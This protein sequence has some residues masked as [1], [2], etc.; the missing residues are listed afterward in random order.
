[1]SKILITGGT[2]YIGSHTAVE[3]LNNGYEVILL[4]NLSNSK[5]DTLDK[6]Q[7]ITNKNF[8]FYNCDV[9]H[10][11]S[12][13]EIFKEEDISSVIHFAGLKSVG[14]SVNK[15]LEYFDTNLTGTITL[16]KVM[17]EFNVKNIIF[18]SSATVYSLTD[19]K[20]ITEDSILGTTNPYGRTKLIG[21][22]ILTDLYNS[23][24]S[25]NIT[26]LRYFNPIG[27]HQSGL[28]G[29]LPSGIPNNLLPYITKVAI[30][31]LD[32][33]NVFG[34]DYPTKDGTGERDYI[35][36]VDLAKGHLA[37]LKQLDSLRIYN[38]GTG[39]PYTVLEI[40]KEMENIVGD[41]IPYKITSRRSGDI[42][43]CFANPEKAF[44]ELNWKAEHQLKRMLEDSWR[45]QRNISK[46]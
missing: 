27:A 11:S 33:L 34:A 38:L 6:I 12:L 8:N 40:L 46:K 25:W 39:N 43:T 18:S 4:D 21:E 14:E 19:G 5:L 24:N 30:G 44:K 45:W 10:E 28:I 36:V 20:H 15:P 32:Y 2:G 35:H 42:A 31:E 23:D 26:I 1:M 16:L 13:R 7:E 9:R 17:E 22:N 3:L 37:A 41:K 29:E